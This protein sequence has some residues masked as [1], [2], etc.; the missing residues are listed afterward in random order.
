MTRA[1]G[2]GIIGLGAGAEPHLK[3]LADLSATMPV[4]IAA[5][6][7]A[8]RAE[9]RRA[10]LPFPVTTN[11]DD[12]VNHLGVEAVIVITPPNTHLDIASACLRAGKHVLV[13]KPIELTSARGRVM[14]DL[15]AA[16]NL[17]LGVMLQ[18]RMRPGAQRLHHLLAERALGEII[19]ASAIVNW[20]RP[21][22]YYDEPG[23]GTLARDGGGVLLTQAIHTLDLFRHLVGVARVEAAQACTT[24]AHR[25]ETEDQVH[26]LVRLGGG[27]QGVVIAS[28]AAFPGF[29]ER[30]EIFG[31]KAGASLTGGAL[32]I[33][34][35]DGRMENIEAEG[36]TGSGASIM[37]FPHDAHRAVIS[38]F[39]DAIR[40]QREP[41]IP[42]HEAVLTQELIEAI[43]SAA[44]HV[45]S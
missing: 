2:I 28:T 35:L 33:A 26:A 3:S 18:H 22:A 25:M 38:D 14:V 1:I 41:A 23:R 8:A 17:R 24:P 44:A 7:S 9:A 29:P 27:G 45:E 31:T 36:R 5:T 30:I 39:G 6:P 15:A 10:A 20:W 21:Q 11:V 40:Q 13:E 42:G 43:L 16:N 12:V 19:S 32:N 4:M 37:D 34:W